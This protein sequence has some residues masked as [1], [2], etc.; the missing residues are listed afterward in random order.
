MPTPSHWDEDPNWPVSDWKYEVGNDD[1]RQGYHEWVASQKEQMGIDKQPGDPE[2]TMSPSAYRRLLRSPRSPVP[3]EF[4]RDSDSVSFVAGVGTR[5]FHLWHEDPQDPVFVV[6]ELIEAGKAVPLDV[7]SGALGSLERKLKELG[8]ELTD[9]ATVHL[10]WLITICRS[11]LG[12]GV[13]E[14]QQS[15]ALPPP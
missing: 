3:G 4:V 2:G 15:V 14:D 8:D 6:G 5:G 9:K 10:E 1:T 12:A 7:L 13:S 11:T